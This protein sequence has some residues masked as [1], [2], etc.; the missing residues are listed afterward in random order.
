MPCEVQQLRM[1]FSTFC[2]T[3]IFLAGDHYTFLELG[4]KMYATLNTV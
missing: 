3:G 4:L 1:L 2:A